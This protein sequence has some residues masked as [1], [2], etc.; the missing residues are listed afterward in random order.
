[1]EQDYPEIT[2]L[3]EIENEAN[4]IQTIL[5]NYKYKTNN[6]P[7]LSEDFPFKGRLREIYSCIIRTAMHIGIEY[8]DI[9]DFIK[10]TEQ[11][12]QEEAE[13][14]DEYQI[15]KIIKNF[16]CQPT[17][18]D[19]PEV[20]SYADIAEQLGWESEKRQ[21]LGYIFKK[22]LILKTKRRNIGSVVLLTEP[23]NARRLKSLYRRFKL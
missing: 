19:S 8:N 12:K 3:N 22:K 15:L 1:M 10:Q 4:R 14:S 9:I 5:L 11:E 21:K 23:K 17:L 2:E 13:N 6:P 20:I 7:E 16:E 18:D